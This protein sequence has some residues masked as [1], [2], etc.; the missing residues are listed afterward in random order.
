MQLIGGAIVLAS[1]AG[2]VRLA[3]SVR[4]SKDVVGAA[5]PLL[6]SNP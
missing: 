2:V 1:L 5:D 6:N 3:N 4:V